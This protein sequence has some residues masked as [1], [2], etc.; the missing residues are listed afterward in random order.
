LNEDYISILLQVEAD[1]HRAM[2]KAVAEAEI[3]TD[4]LRQ[5]QKAYIEELRK[6]WHTFEKAENERL[7]KTL[8]DDYLKIEAKTAVSKERLKALQ[9]KKAELISERLKEEALGLY[10]DC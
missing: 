7:S 6:E 2:K 1:Y 10:G 4:E 9:M 5:K 8:S 3:R